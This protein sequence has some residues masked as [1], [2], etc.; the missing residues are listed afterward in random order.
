MHTP[1][2]QSGIGSIDSAANASLPS[3]I[4]VASVNPMQIWMAVFSL[5]WIFGVIALFIYSIISYVKIKRKLQTA[6]RVEA[7]VFETDA[8]G[9]AFVCGFIRPKIYVPAN[10]GDA[11]LSYILEHERTHIRRKDYLIK[12]L[13]FLALIL[14]WFNPLMWLCFALMSRDME[15]S[16]DESVLHKLGDSA[17]GGYSGSLLALAVKRKGL[18]AANPLAFG[19]SHVRDRIKNVLNFKKP[20]FWVIGV[21][22]MAVC[23]AVIAFAANPSQ[24]SAYISEDYKISLKYP[25]YWEANPNYIERYEGKDGFFQVGAIDG[26]NMSID[27]VAKNDTFHKL[28]PYGSDPKIINRMIDGQEARLILPSDDQPEEMKNQAGL[29]VKYP[30]IL[31]LETQALPYLFSEFEKG[32]Q[33]GLKGHIMQNLCWD[34]LGDD[35]IQYS[36]KNPQDWYDTFKKHVQRIAASSSIDFVKANNPKYGVLLDVINTANTD[37]V[38]K[39]IEENISVIMSSPQEAS[40]SY[41]YI[42]MHKEEY[43]KILEIGKEALPY[44]IDIL[45]SG[46]KGLL[47]SI[48]AT[49]C[50]DIVKRLLDENKNVDSETEK[51]SKEALMA[52]DKWNATNGNKSQ[53]VV[54]PEFTKEEVA[55]ARVVVEEYYRAVAAKDAEAILATMYPQ[56]HLTMER[57]KSGNVQLFGTEK[58][59]LLSI[60]Y[61]SQDSMRKSHKPGGKYVEPEN[62]IVFKVSFNIDYPDKDTGPW[63]EGVYENWSMILIR[64]DKNSPWLIYDQG[65]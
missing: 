20:A 13:A 11:N 27:E 10:I 57:V 61:D 36:S 29:I 5:I 34:I 41:A 25:S 2:I 47:G 33:T 53:D 49:L 28:N 35:N 23:A 48:A 37:D 8:I 15:M 65:Y 38:A 12:P 50:E 52:V 16:C 9:T 30:A 45:E 63:N 14:H 58:R 64:D 44:L 21:A 39:I 42:D 51:I 3:A 43:E 62:I 54:M 1:A 4:P 17:K 19:E 26:E 59:T 56:E 31:A 32:G 18:L 40:N 60:D 6:T 55:A 24:S 22:V 7:N 46:D